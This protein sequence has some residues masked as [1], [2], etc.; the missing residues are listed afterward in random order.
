M[1][2]TR[3]KGGE[4]L[5]AQEPLPNRFVKQQQEVDSYVW[6]RKFNITRAEVHFAL[7]SS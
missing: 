3:D 6:L 1:P 5:N 7:G 2:V 4:G